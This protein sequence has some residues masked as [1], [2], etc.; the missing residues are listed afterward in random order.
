MSPTIAPVRLSNIKPK[1]I[2]FVRMAIALAE[3]NGKEAAAERIA[4]RRW[5]E[6]SV[7]SRIFKSGFAYELMTKGPVA[8]GTTGSW[9]AELASAESAAAE[10]FSLVRQR[11]IIGRIDGLRR[12]PLQTRLVNAATG[13][14]AYWVGEGAAVPVS[15]ASY[16]ENSLPPRKLA[17]LTVVSEELLL[18]ADPAA[19]TFIRDDLA[20]ACVATLNSAFLDP[21]NSGTSDVKPAS[22]SNGAPSLPA[23]GDG[24]ADIRLLIDIFPG[25]LERA[26]LVGSPATFAALHDPLILPGLG[27]RGGEAIGIPAIPATDAGDNLILIDPDG[28]ALGE[29]GMALRVSKEATISML[30]NPTNNSVTP[31]A[32]NLVSLYQCDSIAI[33]AEKVINFLEVR[34]S[35][36]VLTGIDQS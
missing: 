23:T 25:D 29:A 18:S 4:A 6:D 30:D 27:I 7:A 26:V 21:A 35:V 31:T 17:A 3:A 9:A 36:A 8:G 34:P 33:L 20:N 5:G 14:Q 10:F 16:N 28:I 11:S 12:V 19:E 22:V 24:L 15:S 32:T 13:F 1:G 2:D